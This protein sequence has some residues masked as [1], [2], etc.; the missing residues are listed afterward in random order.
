MTLYILLGVFLAMLLFLVWFLYR[1]GHPEPGEPRFIYNFRRSQT[2][3]PEYLA[4][5]ARALFHPHMLR[6]GATRQERLD[7]L[8]GDDL[9]PDPQLIET[10]ATTINV[11][12]E[13]FWPW[14]VQMGDGRAGWY[15]WSPGE[16]F[17]EY[18]GYIQNTTEILEQF[19]TLTV[20][21]KL[22]DGGPYVSEDRGN[23]IVKDFAPDQY[24][25]LYAARQ[26]SGGADFDSGKKKP[27]G[28]WFVCSWTFVLRPVG[29]GQTRL[30]VRLRANSGPA[31]MFFLLRIVIVLGDRAAHNSM[32]ERLKARAEAHEQ[33]LVPVSTNFA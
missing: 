8:P 1:M 5:M 17:P 9:L 31:W 10:R 20:G 16:A 29:T 7:S 2:A 6:T 26:V 23:W 27:K 14:I 18:A 30:L 33:N 13:H 4:L 22:S 15:W 12:V 25:V 3:I 24:L 28:F 19:Q 32:F 11:P 21:Q